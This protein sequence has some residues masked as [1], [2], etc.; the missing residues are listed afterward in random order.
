MP[1]PINYQALLPQQN[2]SDQFTRVLQNISLGGQIAQQDAAMLEHKQAQEKS[3]AYAAQYSN[4]LRNAFSEGS[5]KAFAELTA[6]YPQQREAFKQ[7]WDILSKE[8]KDADFLAGTQA[9]SAI[10]NGKPEVAKDI[11][12]FQISAL[13]NA[14]KDAGKLKSILSNLDEDP[15]NV[16]S[17]IGLILSSVDPEKWGKMTSEIRAAESQPSKLRKEEAEAGKAETEAEF[18]PKKYAADLGLTSAQTNQALALTR[19]Y[20]AETQKLAL[21]ATKG[22]PEKQFE[23]EQKLRKEY[24]KETQVYQ[25]VSESFRRIKS[26]ENTGPGDIA[27]IYA[28]MKML[29]PGSVVREGEFATAQNSGGIPQAVVNAYNKALNG[30]RLAPKQRDSF[31][32]QAGKLHQAASVRENE[33]RDGLKKVAKTYNLKEDNVFSI[34][35]NTKQIVVDY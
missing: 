19:K 24:S 22:D 35:G 18:A 16:A 12:T 34:G 4:D 15:K 11:L 29:D 17:H 6:K 27:L 13:E 5:P 10:K 25:D 9:Y 26:A 14:G 30:E 32:S 33:V 3:Q 20:D 8:Q 28:Y 31:M 2:L 7:S 1:Q 21:E 23:L